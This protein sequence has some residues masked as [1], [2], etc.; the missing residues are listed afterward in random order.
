MTTNTRDQILA[1]WKALEDQLLDDEAKQRQVIEASFDD[2]AKPHQAKFDEDTTEQRKRVLAL[3][4]PH[5]QKLHATM[6]AAQQRFNREAD[7][8]AKKY[9]RAQA[10]LQQM[11]E[12]ETKEQNAALVAATADKKRELDAEW[13]VIAAETD[14]KMR[15]LRDKYQSLLDSL[16]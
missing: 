11:F 7:K 12:K 8:A 14:R 10:K 16:E 15:E 6:T 1:E 9:G 2:Y 5:K 3:L 4:E 13:E